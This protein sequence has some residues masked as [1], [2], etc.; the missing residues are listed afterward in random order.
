VVK[1]QQNLKCVSER[2]FDN[3][4]FGIDWLRKRSDGVLVKLMLYILPA[5]L[6]MGWNRQTNGL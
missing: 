2:E 3:S 6:K 1:K 5:G 4:G